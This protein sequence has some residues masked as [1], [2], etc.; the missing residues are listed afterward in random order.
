MME[1]KRKNE[2]E[3]LHLFEC[4]IKNGIRIPVLRYQA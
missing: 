1:L 4:E 2:K 3:V